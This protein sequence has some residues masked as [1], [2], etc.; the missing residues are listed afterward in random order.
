MSGPTDSAADFRLRMIPAGVWAL[1][2][3]SLFKNYSFELAHSLRPVFL[4]T[5]LGASALSLGFIEG[6]AEATAAVT[7]VYSGLLSDRLGKRKVLTVAGYGL[8]V[9]SEPLFPLAAAV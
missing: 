5:G 2:L 7:K 9:L 6:I 3:V 1:G 4:I 8:A